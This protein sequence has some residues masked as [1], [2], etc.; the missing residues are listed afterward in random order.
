M[1]TLSCTISG[2]EFVVSD[3][4]L[5]LL[6]DFD[7]PLPSIAP[8][9]RWIGMTAQSMP[10]QLSRETCPVTKKPI[11]SRWSPTGVIH[12]ADADWF[13]SDDCDNRDAGQPYDFKRPF[14]DQLIEVADRSFAPAIN[15]INCEDSPYV[16][17]CV[18]LNRCHLC[19]ACENLQDSVYC[20]LCY[21]STDLL[22]CVGCQDSELSYH[23][24]DCREV[25]GSR[26]LQDC[27]NCANCYW[28]VDCIGCSNCFACAGLRQA[29]DGY[30]IRNEKVS[31]EEWEQTISELTFG[32]YNAELRATE[33]AE[34]FLSDQRDYTTNL[35]NENCSA[36]DHVHN[37]K[38]LHTALH[39][40]NCEDC[41]DLILSTNA[42]NCFSSMWI[43]NSERAYMVAGAVN[44]YDC[45]FC[46]GAVG[47][48]QNHTYNFCGYNGCAHLFGCFFLK[49]QSYCILNRQYKP[50]EYR[51]L[52]PRILAHM[53]STG[54]W[55][56]WFPSKLY[57]APFR[58][59]WSAFAFGDLNDQEIEQRGLLNFSF[60]DQRT[61]SEG[62]T[63]PDHINDFEEE[64]CQQEICCEVSGKPFGV[65]RKELSA[66]TKHKAPVMRK[67][68]SV[69][70]TELQHTSMLEGLA[71]I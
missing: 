21:S 53:K 11:L 12:G 54:E 36:I 34:L 5:A 31:K 22:L 13:W 30:F 59:S 62:I 9:E 44:A 71:K 27:I 37:S 1:K 42:R 4:E 60:S 32:S 29:R 20:A 70:L 57:G 50:G 49:K 68:W 47:D 2:K 61:I 55:G 3:E 46:D 24:I 25:Y 56:Q 6:R 26:F 40:T 38:N 69:L 67:H 35:H 18:G 14:F 8:I 63:L 48:A 10:F 66:F 15:R 58:E 33:E 41:K 17:A 39:V 28:C 19:F 64:L 16:N 45:L 52:V 43:H 23:C 65:G 51:E 7:L